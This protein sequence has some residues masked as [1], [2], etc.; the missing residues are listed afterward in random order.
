MAMKYTTVKIPKDIAD[1]IDEVNSRLR[2]GYRSRTEFIL[3]CIRR[4]LEELRSQRG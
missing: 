1:T 2:L 4:R 3:D